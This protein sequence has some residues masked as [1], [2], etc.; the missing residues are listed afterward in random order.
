VRHLLNKFSELA[1]FPLASRSYHLMP[2]KRGVP[3]YWYLNA[4]FETV[5]SLFR[6]IRRVRTQTS[7]EAASPNRLD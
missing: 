7:K 5:L 1:E 2:R 6:K 4:K 3:F